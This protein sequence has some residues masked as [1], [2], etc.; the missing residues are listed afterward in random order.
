MKKNNMTDLSCSRR[1]LLKTLSA[2]GV[3]TPATMLPATSHGWFG[4]WF[5]GRHATAEKSTGFFLS[6]QGDS[7]ERYALSWVN[8]QQPHS[9]NAG[10]RGHGLAQNPTRPSQVVMFARRPGVQGLVIDAQ[11]GQE[12]TRFRCT[13]GKHLHG[14]GVFSQDGQ[15][16]FTSE[17]DIASGRGEICVR[18]TD[19]FKVQQV[20][21]SHGIG[22][23]EIS[24]LPDGKTLVVANGG[25]RTHPDSGR[26]VLNLD[27]MDSSLTLLNSENGALIQQHKLANSKSSIRHLDVGQDGSVAVAIQVQ[28]SAMTHPH[29]VPLAAVLSAGASE[30]KPLMAPEP[31]MIQ[32]KDYMGSVRIHNASQTAAFTSPKGDLVLFWHLPSGD[33]KGFH[34]FHDVCGL[35]LSH[36]QK[37]FVVSNSAGNIRH[38]S[39]DTLEEQKTQR[40]DFPAMQWD[41]HMITLSDR[42]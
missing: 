14:H 24:L 41:N 19:Q 27:T 25:L 26:K 20:F 32:L 6:A 30:L 2:L 29:T 10:F 42:V 4:D 21:A 36:D 35:T 5:S 15:W 18:D 40:M 7:V 22:P 13:S 1:S 33:F 3:V 12:Q 16:L 9:I 37:Y 17:S 23:H 31:L 11:Q 8:Q 38:L 28:R 39:T 34:A